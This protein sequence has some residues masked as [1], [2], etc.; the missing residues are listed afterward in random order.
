[1]K[2]AIKYIQRAYTHFFYIFY[3]S[4]HQYTTST[5]VLPCGTYTHTCNC[6]SFFIIIIF[7]SPQWFIASLYANNILFHST[8]RRTAPRRS[9]SFGEKR[10]SAE[11]KQHEPRTVTRMCKSIYNTQMCVHAACK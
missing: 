5:T 4:L 3:R 7:V 6:V 11:K 9:H 8:G 1:M 10:T 2:I